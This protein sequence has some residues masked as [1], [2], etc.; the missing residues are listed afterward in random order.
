MNYR[1]TLSK[2]TGRKTIFRAF[3][4]ALTVQQSTFFLHFSFVFVVCFR[5]GNFVH[6][7]LRFRFMLKKIYVHIKCVSIIYAKPPWRS[8]CFILC[9]ICYGKRSSKRQMML[10]K[11][12]CFHTGLA[13]PNIKHLAYRKFYLKN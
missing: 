11:E 9:Q 6:Y 2:M 7:V 8:N 4:Y 1:Q 5:L 3:Y 12:N 13:L 10:S